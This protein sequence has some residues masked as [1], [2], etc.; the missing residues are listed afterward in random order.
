M[1]CGKA[2]DPAQ[3]HRPTILSR[4]HEET[5]TSQILRNRHQGKITWLRPRP[6]STPSGLDD[7]GTISGAFPS[8]PCCW[9]GGLSTNDSDYYGHDTPCHPHVRKKEIDAEIL[10]LTS[11]MQ[12]E[13]ISFQCLKMGEMGPTGVTRQQTLGSWLSS[14]PAG[15]WQI[16][17]Y[18]G[19]I[20]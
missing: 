8:H 1:T 15:H 20:R 5:L 16:H 17:V 10:L 3:E 6:V 9:L 19:E 4:G 14:F 11:R 7:G 12:L 18:R 13:V 2:A